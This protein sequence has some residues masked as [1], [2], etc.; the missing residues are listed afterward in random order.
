[1]FNNNAKCESIDD[2]MALA[3]VHKLSASALMKM[4][5]T[6]GAAWGH[7]GFG[8]ECVLKATIM[9]VSQQSVWWTRNERPD[10]YVHDLKKLAGFAGLSPQTI[11]TTDPLAPAWH[12]VFAWRREQSYNPMP[13][14]APV[15]KGLYDAS[16]GQG[17]VVKW[18]NDT[19]HLTT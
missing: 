9:R 11:G 12:T 3:R 15:L 6:R 1:M 14:P 18:L 17:G 7:C 13:M 10:L 5:E 2:W 8:V 16:F 4:P 19:Y